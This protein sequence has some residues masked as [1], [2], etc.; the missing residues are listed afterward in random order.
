MKEFEIKEESPQSYIETETVS[1]ARA[2]RPSDAQLSQLIHEHYN[3]EQKLHQQSLKAALKARSIDAKYNIYSSNYDTLTGLL[4]PH[5]MTALL[6]R[7]L[8]C[9]KVREK[10]LAILYLQLNGL[11]EVKNIYG[12]NIADETLIIIAERLKGA[13]RKRDHLSHLNGN[14]YLVGLMIEKK[15][16]EIVESLSEKIREVIS[17]PINIKGFRIAVRMKISIAAY[18]IH[19]DKVSA[20]LD[21][22]KMKMYKM[23]KKVS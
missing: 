15:D 7:S 21:I 11:K 5:Y 23:N 14:K 6:E 22:A 12:Q 19:G 18:P 13:V 4:N 16:L 1:N 8:Q 20:L 3:R 2:P 9:A 17:R 10:I